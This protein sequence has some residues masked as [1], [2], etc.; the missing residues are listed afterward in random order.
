MIF[1]LYEVK[2][3]IKYYKPV[4]QKYKTIEHH[5][6]HKKQINLLQKRY[7]GSMNYRRSSEML[8][9]LHEGNDIMVCITNFI[10]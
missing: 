4:L 1:K 6:Q 5:Y 10:K 2:F 7:E 3:K 8:T 9:R